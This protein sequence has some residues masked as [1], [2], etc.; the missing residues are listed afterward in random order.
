MESL[1]RQFADVEVVGTGAGS[2]I[3]KGTSVEDGQVYAV[4]VV[5][6]TKRGDE[7]FI[8]Q[9]IN[10]YQIASILDHRNIIKVHSCNRI[11]RFFKT[12]EYDILMEYFPGKMLS[13]RARMPIPETIC[14]FLQ[15]AD[16]LA[17]MHRIGFVHTDIKPENILVDDKA[18]V[19][20]IDFGVACKRNE[21]KDRVQGT[22]EFM[23]PEQTTKKPLDERTDIYNLGATMYKILTGKVVPENVSI[24]GAHGNGDGLSLLKAGV[25]DINAAVP[26]RL[27]HLVEKSSRR[28]RSKRY[29]RM[30]E[31]VEEL[32][33]AL[34][35]VAPPDHALLKGLT[36]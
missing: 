36:I 16:A 21:T 18:G 30:S 26:G 12:I 29:Q 32:A 13:E 9:A 22:P 1:I 7:R 35:E 6:W 23:A 10:E 11:R 5:K 34:R 8:K 17:Y 25:R 20:V 28:S 4:K 15:V 19:K 3:Y 14:V 27:A 33:M 31:V 24:A 2:T